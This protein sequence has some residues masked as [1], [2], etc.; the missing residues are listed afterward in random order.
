MILADFAI[1]YDFKSN[2]ESVKR[3]L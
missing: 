2:R 3:M 1:R